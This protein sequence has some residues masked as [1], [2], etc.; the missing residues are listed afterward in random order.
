MSI[1]E[2]R[3]TFTSSEV[4][5][6]YNDKTYRSYHSTLRKDTDAELIRKLDELISSGM[7]QSEAVKT[8]L[9]K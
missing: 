5:K 6:R 7:S 2:K 3:K 9:K 1:A 4:K 8:L